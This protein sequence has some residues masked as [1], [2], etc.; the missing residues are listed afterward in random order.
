MGRT[1]IGDEPASLDSET[2]CSLGRGLID[3]ESL[4]DFHAG[5]QPMQLFVSNQ[6]VQPSALGECACNRRPL[7]PML[8][9]IQSSQ[10]VSP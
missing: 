6:I 9:V 4:L 7:P 10:G 1:S 5:C 2:H 8:S 3:A